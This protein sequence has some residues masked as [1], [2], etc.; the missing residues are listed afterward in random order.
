MYRNSIQK[1]ENGKK[2]WTGVI[3]REDMNI[4]PR[5]A[6]NLQVS[7]SGSGRWR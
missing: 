1:G 3:T 6:R 7:G 4:T 5:P 2:R